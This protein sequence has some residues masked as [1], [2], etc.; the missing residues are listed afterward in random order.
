M[1]SFKL[2]IG[3]NAEPR[4]IVWFNDILKGSIIKQF[5]SVLGNVVDEK[6][7]HK[8][9]RKTCNQLRETKRECTQNVWRSSQKDKVR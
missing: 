5:T 7:A 6:M 2:I 8:T 3:F 9:A 1:F 4:P